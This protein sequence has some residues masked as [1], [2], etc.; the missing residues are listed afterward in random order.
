MKG[1]SLLAMG[2]N[3]SAAREFRDVYQKYP[4][5]DVAAKAKARLRDMGLNVGSTSAPPKRKR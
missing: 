2:K 4:D 1:Q 5:T 3:D